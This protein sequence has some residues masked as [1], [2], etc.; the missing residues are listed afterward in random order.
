M[1]HIHISVNGKTVFDKLEEFNE[2]EQNSQTMPDNN[3]F[4]YEGMWGEIVPM[5]KN[6]WE[7]WLFK[8][9]WRG[10]FGLVFLCLLPYL[11]IPFILIA[12]VIAKI[13]GF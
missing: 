5:K 1:N 2:F 12:G 9:A 13:L 8:W 4:Y 6:S 10:L 3:T 7:Y 11:T